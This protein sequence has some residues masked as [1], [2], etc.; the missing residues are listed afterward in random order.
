MGAG[1][2]G[3]RDVVAYFAGHLAHLVN[4]NDALPESE[5]FVTLKPF[6]LYDRLRRSLMQ[7]RRYS[8]QLI[9]VW[10]YSPPD[11]LEEAADFYFDQVL[12]RPIGGRKG[13]KTSADTLAALVASH[14]AGPHAASNGAEPLSTWKALVGGPSKLRRFNAAGELF[15]LSNRILKCLDACNRP[16]AEVLRLGLSPKEW[17]VGDT[18]VGV[19][20]LKGAN[21]FLKALKGAMNGEVGRRPSSQELEAAFASAPTPGY[22]TV[23]DFTASPLGA[24]IL[25]RLAGLD[26]TYFV[27]Y[28]AIETSLAEELPDG[29]DEPLMRQDEAAPYIEAAIE[30]RVVAAEEGELLKA[31]LSGQPLTAAMGANLFLRRR[32][33]NEFDGDIAAYVEDLSERMARFAADGEARP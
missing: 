1:G 23:A 18:A 32:L 15:E 6:S 12:D 3:G 5:A 19:N 21:A 31:I 10:A 30:A 33:K 11:T 29:G 8:D 7:N 24:A 28:E 4:G 22:K 20:T 16:Y 27:S 2:K 13:E 25:S 17:L 9:G 26:H 14:A